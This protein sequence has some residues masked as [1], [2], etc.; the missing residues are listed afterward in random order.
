M[1]YDLNSTIQSVFKT[2]DK[3]HRKPKTGKSFARLLKKQEQMYLVY[4]MLSESKRPRTREEIK[5]GVFDQVKV[6]VGC[7]HRNCLLRAQ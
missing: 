4:A 1:R 7:Q 3:I 6:G 5:N 2:I